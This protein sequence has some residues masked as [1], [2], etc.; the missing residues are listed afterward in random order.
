MSKRYEAVSLLRKEHSVELLCKAIGV[1]KSG[2]Y[3]YIN[4][5]AKTISER[6]QK[7]IKAIQQNYT[8][9]VKK[10]MEP[11]ILAVN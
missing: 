1:S 4:C 2:Y 9:K 7:D 11:S 8:T 10:H 6:D 5:P 3:S